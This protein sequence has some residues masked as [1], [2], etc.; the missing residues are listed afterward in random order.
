MQPPTLN[1]ALERWTSGTWGTSGGTPRVYR[2]AILKKR[3]FS[4]G[5]IRYADTKSLKSPMSTRPWRPKLVNQSIDSFARL[6]ARITA[7]TL[8]YDESAVSDT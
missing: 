6:T 3:L 1:S 5:R 8:A 4:R 2:P 7:P